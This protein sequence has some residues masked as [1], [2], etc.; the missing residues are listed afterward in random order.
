[1]KIP[2]LGVIFI[3]TLLKKLDVFYA[4]ADRLN[5]ILIFVFCFCGLKKNNNH[6]QNMSK[7]LQ[8]YS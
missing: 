3:P 8:Q 1:M 2:Y 6:I 5:T 7:F 4:I